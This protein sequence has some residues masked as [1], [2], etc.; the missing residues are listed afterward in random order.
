[1]APVAD[2]SELC[3]FNGLDGATG[4]YLTPPM[5][6]RALLEAALGKFTDNKRPG[7]SETLLAQVISGGQAGERHLNELKARHDSAQPHFGVRPGS[8][9]GT[10]KR[11]AG[12]SSSPTTPTRRSGTPSPS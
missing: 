10:W 3:V 12:A 2:D 9:P 7:K 6:P 4:K 11:P 5:E 1:M 8:T